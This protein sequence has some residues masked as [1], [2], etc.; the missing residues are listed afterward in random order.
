MASIKKSQQ[1]SR[2]ALFMWV[3]PRSAVIMLFSP[4]NHLFFP[5]DHQGTNDFGSYT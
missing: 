1:V 2:R 3:D 4:Y 5:Q